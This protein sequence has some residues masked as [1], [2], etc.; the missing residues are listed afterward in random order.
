MG[1]VARNEL[2]AVAAHV[3]YTWR[4]FI[5]TGCRMR[6]I[7]ELEIVGEGSAYVLSWMLMDRDTYHLPSCLIEIQNDNETSCIQGTII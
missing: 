5:D 7:L 2:L 3:H 1:I 4:I 6:R